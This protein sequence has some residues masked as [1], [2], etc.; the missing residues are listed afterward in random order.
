MIEHVYWFID[1][2]AVE[3]L[4]RLSWREYRARYRRR[5]K[6]AKSPSLEEDVAFFLGKDDVDSDVTDI[7]KKRS[8]RWTIQQ[9]HSPLDFLNTV[10][11][12]ASDVKKR[13]EEVWD[14]PANWAEG[15]QIMSVAT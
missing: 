5:S 15:A 8:I 6:F 1:K 14:R 7:L 9:S 11:W 2:A 10:V 12:H 3:P 4:V 13:C